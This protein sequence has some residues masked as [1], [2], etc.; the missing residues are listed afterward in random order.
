MIKYPIYRT[1]KKW[2]LKFEKSKIEAPIIGSKPAQIRW[3]AGKNKLITRNHDNIEI[4]KILFFIQSLPL[5][6]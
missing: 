4:I 1:K 3:D 6:D 5:R 2:R